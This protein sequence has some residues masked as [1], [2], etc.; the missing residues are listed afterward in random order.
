MPGAKNVDRIVRFATFE[1]NI[2]TGELRKNG[3]RIRLNGQPISVLTMLIE[4]SGEVVTREDLQ[5]RLWPADTYVDFEHSLN[6][7]IKR[8]R[9][10][11]RDSAD[12]P[13]YVETLPRVGYRFIAPVSQVASPQPGPVEVLP[14]SMR[15]GPAEGQGPQKAAWRIYVPFVVGATLVAIGVF[16]WGNATERFWRNPIADA[17]YETVTDFDGAQQDAT[18]SR[19]GH[20][21]AFLSDRDGQMDVWVTQVGSGQFH[22][23]THGDAAELINPSVRTLAFSPDDSFVAFWA[24]GQRN[25]KGNDI[26]IWAAPTLG[27]QP[28]PFL[29]GVAE[30]DWSPDGSLVAYHTPGP[31]DPLYVVNVSQRRKESPIF[32]A[33]SGL[34]SHFPSW[35]SNAKY[36][37]FV[38]GTLPDKLDVWRIHPTGG[39][40]ERITAQTTHISHP[41][42]LG[43]RT[44]LYLATEADGSGPRI[45]GLD[46]E[47]RL[48]HRL[49][50]GLDRYT[51][52][53][54][55]ADGHR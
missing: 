2:S 40:A 35:A 20:F 52:L 30:L 23:L 25:G 15:T 7:A 42:L 3:L 53:A 44:L 43:R 13:R 36:I 54:A 33:A 49:T 18:I 21:V 51:S 47:R 48:P 55:S 32:T 34:H 22:N 28:R 17:R 14:D 9:A 31:G 39:L 11:L 41:V 38:Q 24:R 26:N 27:G 12:T 19:D 5:K 46:V 6:A 50:N 37:Y 10:A 29:E 16:L 1:L 8:L 4:R 45:Y